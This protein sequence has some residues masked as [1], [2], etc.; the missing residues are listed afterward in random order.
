MN[1]NQFKNWRFEEYTKERIKN[2]RINGLQNLHIKALK[3]NWKRIKK[4]QIDLVISV[5]PSST[6]SFQATLQLSWY[7]SDT[8]QNCGGRG[9]SKVFNSIVEFYLEIQ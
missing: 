8:L 5:P 6:G 7:T 4:F 1:W 3:E 2:V 9:L